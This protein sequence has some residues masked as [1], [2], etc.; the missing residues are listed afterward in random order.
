M[1]TVMG[2]N[3]MQ[4]SQYGKSVFVKV[5]HTRITPVKRIT[6]LLSRQQFLCSKLRSKSPFLYGIQ[7]IRVSGHVWTLL[8]IVSLFQISVK[9]IFKEPKGKRPFL[10]NISKKNLT[11]A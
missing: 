1:T 4:I 5:F 9:I 7:G 3:K 8:R 11:S 2:M 10:T 6:T